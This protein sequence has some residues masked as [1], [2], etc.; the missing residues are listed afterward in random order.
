MGSTKKKLLNKTVALGLS[1]ALVSPFAVLSDKGIKAIAADAP[2]TGAIAFSL[3]DDD[4]KKFV[5]SENV[6][7]NNLSQ[8]TG[9]LV[10]HTSAWGY[11]DGTSGVANAGT[12][13]ITKDTLQPGK[14]AVT[15]KVSDTLSVTSFVDVKAGTKATSVKAIALPTAGDVDKAKSGKISSVVAPNATVVVKNATTAWTTKA[16][17]NGKFTVYVPAGSYDV[18]VDSDADKKNTKYSIK[19][20]AGQ[21]NLP[22]DDLAADSVADD[23]LGYVLVN[24][25]AGQPSI[26]AASKE[27][28]GKAIQNSKVQAYSVDDNATAD[29]TTDDVYTL[30]GET[31]TKKGTGTSTIGDFSIKLKE[32]QPGK[33]IQLVV[34][35]EALN[36][37]S[38]TLV[39]LPAIDPGFAA[40]TNAVVGKDVTITFTDKSGALLTSQDLAVSLKLGT[41][42]AVPLTKVTKVGTVTTGDYTITSGKLTILNKTILDNITDFTQ[43]TTFT[44]SVTASNFEDSTVN[45]IVKAVAAPSLTASVAKATTE[46]VKLTAAAT[47]NTTNEIR[48]KI[49]STSVDTPKLYST[50]SDTTALPASPTDDITGVDATTNKYLAVYEL[51]ADDQIVKFKQLTLT[52]TNIKAVTAVTLATGSLGTAGNNEITGLTSAKKYKV[53]EGTTVSYVKA[54]GTLGTLAD[55]AALTGTKITGLTNG[56]TYKV[57]DANSVPTVATAITAQTG[58]VGTAVT[59]DATNT[60]A[61]AD[62]TD[63]LTLTAVSDTT[64]TAT[65]NVTGKTITITPVAAGTATITLTADDGFG[66]KVSTTFTITVS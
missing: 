60:F 27:Y 4:G 56:K 1:V 21:N 28:K 62:T 16:D 42:A 26:N 35:D 54:D 47:R 57:E 23:T 14:Y 65:V 25:N 30:I 44:I 12:A 24:D 19:V 17:A 37:Y 3:L 52:A 6:V 20:Q 64:A 29:D 33:K 34:E 36:S 61:D 10:D 18:I 41:G 38:P 31:V 59:V 40:M 39:P 53:T 45:Q 49:S 7:F 32:A 11:G 8:L 58:A 13:A 48:Y 51:N 5:A 66:G 9:G 46:G 63:T 22:F 50:V 43:D 15:A 2:T 55:V